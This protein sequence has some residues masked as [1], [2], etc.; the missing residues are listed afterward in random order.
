MGG[1]GAKASERK[2]REK[3]RYGEVGEERWKRWRERGENGDGRRGKKME[4]DGR[5]RKNIEANGIEKEVPGYP[6]GK[7]AG[8]VRTDGGGLDQLLQRRRHLPLSPSI[9]LR[10]FHGN[11]PDL[12]R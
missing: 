2:K 7:R 11:V 12:A 10:T 6:A 9:S 4:R 8:Q 1:K 5:R 3:M